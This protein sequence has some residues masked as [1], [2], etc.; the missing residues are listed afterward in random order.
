MSDVVIGLGDQNLVADLTG[1]L[2]EI[3]DVSIKAV[4]TTTQELI[5]LSRRMRPDIVI[6]YSEIGPE[7]ITEIIRDITA[8]RPDVAVLEVSDTRTPATVVKAMEAGARGVIAYPFSFPD[9]SSR[10]E[11]A[12]EWVSHIRKFQTGAEASGRQRGTVLSVVGAKGGVGTTTI[13]THLAQDHVLKHPDAKVCLVDVDVEK[14]DIG[15]VL[16]VR[17][18]V[19][20]ADVAKVAEDLGT[21][22][23]L[24]AVILHETG[25]HVLL[26]PADV[27]EADFVTPEALQAIV[28]ILRREFDVVII[29]GGGHVSP[30]Q[31]ASVEVA[32]EVL[33]VTTAD[34]MSVRAMRRR[35]MAW[36]AL[37]VGDESTMRVLVNKV[38][39][40]SIFPAS[41]VPRLTTARVT[42][43]RIPMSTRLLEV[44]QNERNPRAITEVA[45][46][47]LL[48]ELRREVGLERPSAIPPAT[49][50]PRTRRR[51]R[52]AGGVSLENAALIPF[53]LVLAAV[54]WQL[55]VTGITFIWAGHA[56]T[57]AARAY[58]VSHQTSS[59]RSAAV[60]ALPGPFASG[61]AVATPTK[62][63]ISVTVN[64]PMGF[65]NVVGLPT[66]LTTSRSV[67]AE[68]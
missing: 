16:D 23:V 9:V 37:S 68:P 33:V 50:V 61:L 67:V 54:A 28:E 2:Q 65:G 26:A 48:S 32:D 6:A 21:Q 5:D 40:Q 17:Q 62:G 19:S 60:D 42:E 14:G 29:D 12:Q 35:M 10:L 38:D 30:S 3:D 41:A 4:A 36:T 51:K 1:I 46:W 22:T 64:I 53:V 15:A 47:R 20:I 55:A 58:A 56:T 44:A 31:A 43:T 8:Q 57:A 18:S 59:A 11:L 49:A 52:E 13:A 66:T 24:D 7:P 45:W 39:K 63:S 25:I 34:V 27:R